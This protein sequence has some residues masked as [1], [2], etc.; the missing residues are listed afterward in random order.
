MISIGTTT[1]VANAT[2]ETT[3]TFSDG[4]LGG[5]GTELTGVTFSLDGTTFSDVITL[6]DTGTFPL[7]VKCG[8]VPGTYVAGI[9]WYTT[10]YS[11]MDE[12]NIDIT[13]TGGTPPQYESFSFSFGPRATTVQ[14][15]GHLVKTNVSL[16]R[17][18]TGNVLDWNYGYEI[19]RITQQGQ[20]NIISGSAFAEKLLNTLII[21][22]V[23][24]TFDLLHL[25]W[26]RP[27]LTDH[28]NAISTQ[29]GIPI[30]LIGSNFYPKTDMNIM[31]RKGLGSFYER[32]SGSFGE[33]INKLIGWSDT[34]PGMVY[35]MLVT[36]NHIY[37]IQ[38]GN[39]TNTY[40]QT[41]WAVMPTITRSIRRTEW[42]NSATQVYIPKQISS[43]DSANSNEPYNGTITWGSTSLTYVDGYLTTEVRG[44]LTTTYTYIDTND[45]KQLTQKETTDTD[46]DTYSITTYSYQTT[47][48]ETYL[49]EE[50]THIYDGQ[51]ATGVLT[52]ATLTRHV[53]IGGGW[54]GSTV[55][56]IAD[57]V[58]EELSNSLSQGAPGQKPN[59]Y[60]VDSM[61]DSLKPSSGQGSQRQMIV[62]L[63][64]VARARQTYP[65]ADYNTLSAIASN[66]DSYEGKT[67]YT[68]Q[69]D[70]VGGSHIYT[71]NDKIIYNGDTYYLVSNNVSVNYSTIRQSITAVRFV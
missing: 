48:A 65:V 27:S 24:Y 7:Y 29:I 35:N 64:G 66:L 26:I 40:T 43:S 39:E 57:G 28:L 6:H 61:N 36:N 59:Q 38:R 14:Y 68:L 41:A 62:P 58:E 25:G 52:A 19:E 45:G 55:Y 51:D 46:N 1:F 69:G 9:G 71:F 42:G 22:Q 63:T 37:I 49:F 50:T 67:E 31:L 56:D 10:D 47:G 3:I 8:N 4:S 33:L 2:T 53:P 12:G 34:V 60:L 17:T 13:I 70:I 16:G 5:L 21:Y 44:N 15:N 11:T 32:I 54:Y 18:M 30:T 20:R 23:Q